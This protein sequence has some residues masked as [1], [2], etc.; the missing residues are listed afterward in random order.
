LKT[1]I[2]KRCRPLALCALVSVGGMGAALAIEIPNYQLTDGPITQYN[3]QISGDI[4]VW[5][6]YRNG[7]WDIY[8]MDLKTHQEF[9]VCTNPAT[10]DLPYIQ[11]NIVV[12][13]DLR[14]GNWDIYG[15]NLVTGQEFPVCVADGMQWRPAVYGSFVVWQDRRSG[16]WDIYGRDLTGGLTQIIAAGPGDQEFPAIYR[17][18][19][20]WADSRN[21]DSNILGK[22]ISTGTSFV[23]ANTVAPESRPIIYG[24]VVVWRALTTPPYWDIWA[25]R[26]STGEVIPVCT[27]SGDQWYANI[28]GDIIVWDDHRGL[29]WDI[30]GYNLV[31]RTEFPISRAKRDQ[32]LPSIDGS[33]VV[34][35]DQRDGDCNLWAADVSSQLTAT[36]SAGPAYLNPGTVW[37]AF[38][39]Q[40]NNPDPAQILGQDVAVNRLM[41][42]NPQLR[43]IETYPYDFTQVAAGI[44]YYLMLDRTLSVQYAGVRTN[45]DQLAPL[46]YPGWIWL[47]TSGLHDVALADCLARKVATG[48]VRTAAA[49]R[50][51]ANPWITWQFIY[52]D[53]A[54]DL[55]RIASLDGSGDDSTLHPWYAYRL[56]M[57]VEG[58]D[59]ILPATRPWKPGG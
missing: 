19:V 22:D 9:P 24:D 52:W 5:A 46:R 56:W 13:R 11:G 42:W 37:L 23:V 8:G 41:R 17:S 48:E 49:D 50:R 14:N 45:G 18:I 29:T 2:V 43:V 20:L 44:G 40:P 55:C 10:Q 21:G 16:D 12:W 38:P 30:Y 51:S 39:V 59:L 47:G 15:R 33:T 34:W 4:I 57:T 53:P 58:I 26:L 3:V 32:L 25:K 6:D 7:N 1:G 35:H 36:V 27:T 28:C 54:G 31:T